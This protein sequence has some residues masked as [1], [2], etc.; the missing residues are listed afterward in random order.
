MFNTIYTYISAQLNT[1]DPVTWVILFFISILYD[2]IYTKSVLYISKLNA[3]PAANLS[4]ILYIIMAYGTINYVKN[5]IN[6]IPIILG[7]WIGTYGILKYENI[8]YK[9]WKEEKRKRKK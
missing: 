3:I 7:A 2:I 5:F 9:K 1:I 8:K 4:V 6:I